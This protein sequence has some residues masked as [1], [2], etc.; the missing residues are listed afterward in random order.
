MI[1]HKLCRRT[2]FLIFKCGK[3]SGEVD[4]KEKDET[5][6]LGLRRRSQTF[7]VESAYLLMFLL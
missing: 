5:D 7:L 1:Y 2:N 6:D 4:K 3:G